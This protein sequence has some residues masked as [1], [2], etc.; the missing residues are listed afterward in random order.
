MRPRSSTTLFIMLVLAAARAGLAA[1]AS[2]YQTGSPWPVMRA[3]LANSGRARDLNYQPDPAAP[4]SPVHFAT[5]NG[6]FSTPVLDDQDRIYVGSADHFFYLFDPRTAAAGWKFDARELI[7]SAAALGRDG[8]IYVP[9]GA[10]I[11]AL[12]RDGQEQ[13]AF[14]VTNNRPEGLY[15]FGTNYWWE[16]NVVIGPEGD[17]YSGNDDF[18]FYRV[19]PEGRMRWAFRTGFLIWSVPAFGPDHD[20]YFAGFDM[21]LYA[22]NRETGKL[23]WKTNLN[24][25]LVSSPALGDDGVL[26]QGSFDGNLYALDAATGKLR[27]TLKTDS[28]I[29]ASAAIAPDRRVYITSTDGF[30]YAADAADG[31]VLW[32]F[33]TGDAVRSSPAIG[34]DPEHRAAYLVYFGGGQ[35]DLYAIDP[36]GNRR[37]SYHTLTGLPHVDYPNLNAS[38]ALGRSGIAIANA[39]GDVFY[40]PYDYYLRPNAPGVNRDPSEGFGEDGAHWLWVAPGGLI[41][42]AAPDVIHAA[43]A[44]ILRLAVRQQGRII[45]ARIDPGSIRTEAAPAFPHRVEM[46][47]DGKTLVV[48]PEVMLAPGRDYSLHVSARYAGRGGEAGTVDG[49]FK[50]RVPEAGTA[51]ALLADARTGFVLEHMAFPQPPII[52]SMDQIGIAIMRIPVAVV[53]ADP[54]RGTFIAWAVQKY[55]AAAGGE[56]QG[57]PDSRSLFYAFAGEARGDYFRI[58]SR[59][60]FFEESSFPFPLDIFRLS[61]RLGST[62]AVDK[63]ASL[64]AELTPPPML[65]ALGQLKVSSEQQPKGRQSWLASSLSGGASKK[66]ILGA[67]RATGPT[68]AGFISHHV[69]RPWDLYNS[70]GKFV[71]AGTFRTEPLPAASLAAPAGLEVVAFKYDRARRE[72]V[73]EVKLPDT[74]E[75][76]NLTLAI[77]V[78]DRATGKPVP[79]NYNIA[80]AR[81]RLADGNKHTVLA[82][83]RDKSISGSVT[84][85][86]MLDLYPAAKLDV[87]P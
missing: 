48:L 60:C 28:H 6:V 58:E 46:I 84:A 9:A 18:F 75:N 83:P 62:A 57:I 37:W 8:R 69:W 20:M 32:T 81:Q 72:L 27:W 2:P 7:D 65:K 15:T 22:L 53:E 33:Y 45:S 4:K 66:G 55:G 73:G 85:Y 13:W 49:T 36:D 71:T 23:K 35:G 63:D 82:L 3:D 21:R 31:R 1:D 38:P 34:P 5:G 16:G 12:D 25:P 77:L 10:A 86:L 79:V 24:N 61:G 42:P 87:Q 51:S 59:N 54:A 41:E 56:E 52:P 44:V 64:Y 19:S 47:G 76:Q 74:R 40:V 14:D 43:Q 29:Y 11:Y 68:A 78:I 39:N 70:S 67:I 26:Y 80:L 30:L 50:L 17:L